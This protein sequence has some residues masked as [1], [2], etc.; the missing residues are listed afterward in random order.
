MIHGTENAPEV[1]WNPHLL[2]AK[3]WLDIL[4]DFTRNINNS[5]HRSIGRTP[6]SVTL[7]NAWKVRELLY[8]DE[9]TDKPCY[10]QPGDIVRVPKKKRNYAKGYERKYIRISYF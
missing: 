3:R 10:F 8:E 5:F 2:P 6:A 9:R 4:P 1:D 7:E